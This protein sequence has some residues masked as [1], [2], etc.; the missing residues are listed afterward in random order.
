ME[1]LDIDSIVDNII[2]LHRDRSL[3]FDRKRLVSLAKRSLIV[4]GENYDKLQNPKL[5]SRNMY[6]KNWVRSVIDY[7]LAARGVK[8]I[9][10]KNPPEDL[11][12]S[13]ML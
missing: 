6:L 1:K 8:K 5:T 10:V 12:Y 4:A 9:S 2:F 3:V 7:N 11:K 13:V